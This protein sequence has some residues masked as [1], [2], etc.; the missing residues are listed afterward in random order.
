MEK[1]TREGGW[2]GE[3]EGESQL[4]QRTPPHTAWF[5]R[6]NTEMRGTSNSATAERNDHTQE[7]T[8]HP[9]RLLHT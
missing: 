9:S 3:E 6:N 7:N 2:E 8:G 4:C 5:G 1:G